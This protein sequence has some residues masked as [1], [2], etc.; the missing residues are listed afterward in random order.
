MHLPN[1]FITLLSL[2]LA[3]VPFTYAA[4]GS[5][6]RVGAV[7]VLPESDSSD[8]TTGVMVA[9]GTSFE[10]RDSKSANQFEFELGYAKWDYSK[11]GLIGGTPYTAEAELTFA[12]ALLTYRYQ[13]NITE[14][15]GLAVGP[16]VGMTYVEG[17]GS[18]TSGGSTLSV[19][20]HDWVFSYGAGLQL[21]FQVTENVALTLGYRYLFNEDASFDIAGTEIELT[22]MDARLVEIGLRFAWPD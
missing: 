11:A 19:S 5:Y 1:K 3:A 21:N 16:S 9:F 10:N 20:D 6:V 12:P 18:A 22:D 4:D 7:Q 14:R 13:W 8:D 15:L 2:C 17:S